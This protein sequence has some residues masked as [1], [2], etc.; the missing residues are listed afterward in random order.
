LDGAKDGGLDEE[1]MHCRVMH[2]RHGWFSLA[3]AVDA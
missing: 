2:V 3:L 1:L